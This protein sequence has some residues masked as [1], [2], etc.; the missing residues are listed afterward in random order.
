[1]STVAHGLGGQVALVH[2]FGAVL[3]RRAAVL[4]DTL[5]LALAAADA[6]AAGAE[7]RGADDGGHRDGGGERRAVAG[8]CLEMMGRCLGEGIGD[9]VRW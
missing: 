3:A 4:V 7:G 6:G 8:S 9:A 1:M 2:A 5:R